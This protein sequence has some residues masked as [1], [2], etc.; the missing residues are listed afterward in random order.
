MWIYKEY[1]SGENYG[2]LKK[3]LGN[4]LFKKKLVLWHVYLTSFINNSK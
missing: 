3:Q 2:F 4:R 1:V